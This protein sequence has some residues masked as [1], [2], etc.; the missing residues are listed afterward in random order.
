[1][2]KLFNLAVL[3]SAFVIGYFIP[4][5]VASTT[6]YLYGH[7]LY[8]QSV[9]GT[10]VASITNAGVLTITGLT[11][12]GGVTGTTGVFSSGVSA[13]TGAFSST[14][15]ANGQVT[16]GAD[17]TVSTITTAGAAT[18]HTSVA[19]PDLTATDDLVVG[20]DASV[21]DALDVNGQT[22]LGADNTVSTITAAGAATFHASVSAPAITGTTSV[23]GAKVVVSGGPLTFYSRT[24]AQINAI[25]TVAVGDTYYCSDCTAVTHCAST[26]TVVGSFVKITDKTAV[27]D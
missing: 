1:M 3:V 26:G 19:A 14:L 24:K 7:G 15:D 12:T 27:C 13:T 18:F 22:T 6:G 10:T 16:L 21:T 23:T 8:I 17:N 11:N 25:A 5:A 2:K 9:P 4:G 20:D